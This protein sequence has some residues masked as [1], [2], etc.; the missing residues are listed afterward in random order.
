MSA[1]QL[2]F[3]APS[4]S[5]VKLIVTWAPPAMSSAPVS[6]APRRTFAPTG[7]G[8]R[9]PHLLAAVVHRHRDAVH[10]H[11]LRR[12]H[13]PERQGE[14][15]VGDRAAERALLLRP[16]G[17]DVDPLVVAGGVGEEVHLLLG[18]LHVVGVPEVLSDLVLQPGDAV[19]DRR[20][21]LIM[22][23]GYGSG[24]PQ[25]NQTFWYS[26]LCGWTSRA[27]CATGKMA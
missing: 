22:P 23:R 15:A 19:D 2:G 3:A 21:A 18:D 13:R 16:L 14:V 1:T 9:E 27:N 6:S 17:V 7:H 25:W 5:K 12:E 26:R 11:D 10:P 4:T 20:H 24:S 8:R